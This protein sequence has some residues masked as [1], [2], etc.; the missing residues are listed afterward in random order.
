[1]RTQLQ[2][3]IDEDL[4]DRLDNLRSRTGIPISRLIDMLLREHLSVL[5]RRYPLTAEPVVQGEKK[6]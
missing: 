4:R 5:E 1:M 3:S 2:L 6:V